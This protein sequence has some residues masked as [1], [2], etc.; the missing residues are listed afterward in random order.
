MPT[1]VSFRHE[2]VVSFLTVGVVLVEGIS[3]SLACASIVLLALL[4]VAEP[5]R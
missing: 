4:V 1:H 2:Q 5:T 3:S